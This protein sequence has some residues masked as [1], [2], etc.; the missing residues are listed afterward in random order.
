MKFSRVALF[1]AVLLSISTVRANSAQAQEERLTIEKKGQLWKKT[2]CATDAERGN[3]TSL[4]N[5]PQPIGVAWAISGEMKR[6]SEPGRLT[7]LKHTQESSPF[8]VDMTLFWARPLDVTKPDY[9]VTQIRLT[10]ETAGFLAE[11]SRY[12]AA[13]LANALAIGSCS[14]PLEGEQV[15]VSVSN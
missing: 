14:G 8:R 15:G 6:P 5:L 13:E 11:C 9:I 4:C 3:L 7:Q 2:A 10:H 12:N 1:S